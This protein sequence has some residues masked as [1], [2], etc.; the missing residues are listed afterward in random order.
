MRALCN[1]IIP[2]RSSKTNKYLQ[3]DQIGE[4]TYGIVLKC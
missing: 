3:L 2:L 4:G 1:L